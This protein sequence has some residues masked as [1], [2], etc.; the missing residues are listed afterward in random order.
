MFTLFV[1]G[2]GLCSDNAYRGLISYFDYAPNEFLT[3]D[4]DGN[5]TIG[6]TFTEGTWE[7]W[8]DP[9]GIIM[10][11]RDPDSAADDFIRWYRILG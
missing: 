3:M 1:V 9:R 10:I 2:I 6:A 4:Q 11:G 5:I 8:I 7:R